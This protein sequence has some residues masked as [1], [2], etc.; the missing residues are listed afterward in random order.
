[1]ARPRLQ[2][3]RLSWRA[4]HVWRRDLLVYRATWWSNLVPPLL[5]PVLYLLAFGAGL[6]SLVGDLSYQGVRVGY[7]QFIAPGMLAIAVMF[8]AFY[9]TLYG[10]FVRMYYQ[11][12]FDA[13]LATPLSLEDVL[14]GEILWGTTKALVAAS[15]MLGVVTLFGVVSWPSSWWVLPI[16]LL[17]GFLFA[18]LGLCFTAICPT[19][20]TFNLPVFLF[21]FPMFLFSGTFFPMDVLPAWAVR[22]A[23]AL[24]LT[25]VTWLLRAATLGRPAPYLAWNLAYLLP[26]SFV[27]FFVSLALMRRRLI[28]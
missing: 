5:E 19:I 22:L 27:L 3:T 2:F 25:H 8:W 11:K 7:L 1:V 24:P 26:C 6:G 14:L 9:E 10:S 20:D 17:G 16:S 23:W 12:T 13:I 15:V 4:I 28:R 18:S 21:V